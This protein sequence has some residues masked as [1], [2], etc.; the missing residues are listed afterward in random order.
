[1]WETVKMTESQDTP[2]WSPRK[3]KYSASWFLSSTFSPTS[4]FFTV[5]F[6]HPFPSII[7]LLLPTSLSFMVNIVQICHYGRT[8]LRA[9]VVPRTA[10][11]AS[12]LSTPGYVIQRGQAEQELTRQNGQCTDLCHVQIPTLYVTHPMQLLA[13]LRAYHPILG[14]CR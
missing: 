8:I 12:S 9:S 7:H 4:S 13:V 11:S 1:M 2:F 3:I 14:P 10:R 6:S 5:F